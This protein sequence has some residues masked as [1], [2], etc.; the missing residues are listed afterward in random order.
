MNYKCSPTSKKKLAKIAI[1]FRKKYCHSELVFPIFEIVNSFHDEGLLN[2]I[3]LDDNS[4]I[5]E[6]NQLALYVPKDNIIY[7]R[8]SVYEEAS[9]NVGRSRFTL[10]HEFAHYLLLNVM[11][12]DMVLTEEEIKPFEG[13]EWQENYLASE[14]LAP[15]EMTKGFSVSDYMN[16]CLLSEECAIVLW[17]KRR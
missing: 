6:D 10:T 8:L 3:V 4:S 9:Q 12:F 2:I 17:D 7:I 16:K 5:L 1:E 13:P 14:L 11:K 15:E